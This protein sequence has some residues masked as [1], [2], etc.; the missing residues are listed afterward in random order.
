MDMNRFSRNLQRVLQAS[1]EISA[2]LDI[3]YI[4]SEHVV[5]AMLVT[6]EC[7][8]CKVL[9]ACGVTESDYKRYLLKSVD[10]QCNIQGFTPRTKHMIERA[11]EI[12]FDFSE[13]ALAGSE[14][15]LHAVMESPD[16]L[17]MHIFRALGVSL[18]VLA[19]KL[20]IAIMGGSFSDEGDGEEFSSSF[21]DSPMGSFGG[22]GKYSNKEESKR[23][24]TA[25]PD[26]ILQY[27]TDLTQKAKEGKI[28][29]VIGRKKEIDKIIQ[30]LS[31]RTKNN[32]VLIG[33][34]GVGKSAV[35]EGL[36]QAI[37]K[38]EV[39][40]LLKGKTVFSLDIAS[41]VAAQSTAA[42][43]RKGSKTQ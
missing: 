20:E 30:V 41:M 8:A 40:D 3:T 15:L 6:R 14:H 32:P 26:E 27:G 19:A 12:A 33:E 17:A 7:T 21:M 35:V 42:T 18:P 38:N 34:P 29:P 25:L 11:Q 24:E 13:D 39:P 37:V 1:R 16:C 36:A 43:S 2:S 23:G 9:T 10:R 5:Y 4:G 28:D 22:Q 31:R